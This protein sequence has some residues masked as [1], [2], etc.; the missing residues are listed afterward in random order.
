MFN[1][2]VGHIIKAVLVSFFATTILIAL[3][4][5]IMFKFNVSENVIALGVTVIYVLSCGLG[6]FYIGKVIGERKFM[7]GLLV[8]AIYLV[9][10]F[11]VS[12]IVGGDK[13]LLSENVLSLV[14]LCLG[15]GTLGGM[16]A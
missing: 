15:G 3:F 8:G 5:F 7:W 16:L 1:Q 4:A 12:A 13:S 2:K 10:L 9:V 11:M 14:L 6:G